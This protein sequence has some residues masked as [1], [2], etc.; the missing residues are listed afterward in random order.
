MPFPGG[1][2]GA[3]DDGSHQGSAKRNVANGV[4]GL[5]S[6]GRIIAPG[7]ILFLT[8]S[9]G[10]KIYLGDQTSNNWAFYLERIANNDF[11]GYIIESGAYKQIQT[12]S[13]IDIAGGILGFNNRSGIGTFTRDISLA[14]G[15]QAVTGVGFTPTMVILLAAVVGSSKQSLGFDDGTNHYTIHDNNP[16]S[17]GTYQKDALNSIKLVQ[18]GSNYYT[19][20]ISSLDADGF[21]VSWTKTGTLSGTADIYYLAFR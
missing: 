15:T 7:E 14:T 3:H 10:D 2:Q 21:T 9:V 18:D 4:P 11:T 13:M 1:T 19:G 16:V 8:R 5:D 6:N 12:E 17:A 20:N